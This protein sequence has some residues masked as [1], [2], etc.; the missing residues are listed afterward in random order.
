MAVGQSGLADR[1]DADG[2]CHPAGRVLMPGGG[3]AREDRLGSTPM[4]C[5]GSPSTE[6][7]RRRC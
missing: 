1:D 6:D 3:A 7:S 5:S 2:T 4:K